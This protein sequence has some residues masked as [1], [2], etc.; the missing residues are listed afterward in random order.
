MSSALEVLEAA[1]KRDEFCFHGS[2]ESIS[3]FIRPHQAYGAQE[4]ERHFAV[5]ASTDYRHALFAAT[6]RPSCISGCSAWNW[7]NNFSEIIIDG[8]GVSFQ[9]GYVYI[10]KRKNFSPSGSRCGREFICPE[11]I[12]PERKI[13]VRLEDLRAAEG[14]VFNVNPPLS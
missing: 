4:H 2:P 3:G 11:A 12:L 8:Y 14:V 5:Y 10:L 13:L 6:A 1:K 7:S 9:S